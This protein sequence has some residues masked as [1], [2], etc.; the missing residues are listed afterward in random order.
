EMNLLS[1]SMQTLGQF[2]T[3]ITR[4]DYRNFLNGRQRFAGAD[5]VLKTGYGKDILQIRSRNFRQLWFHT[6]RYK[7]SVVGEFH[8]LARIRANT[9]DP[10]SAWIDSVDSSVVMDLNVAFLFERFR[11]VRHQIGRRDFPGE[12]IR[13]ATGAI[14]DVWTLLKNGDAKPRI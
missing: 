11:R 7:Q 9:G 3:D 12:E 8:R 14:G 1:V 4:A 2:K 5:R 13:N 6:G 10:L